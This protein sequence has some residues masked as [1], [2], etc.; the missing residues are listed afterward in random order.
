MDSGDLNLQFFELVF[1]E[2]NDFSAFSANHMIVML[3]EVAVLI[4]GLA[5]VKSASV[6]KTKTAHELQGFAHKLRVHLAAALRQ[7]LG[8]FVNGN[9]L[10]GL[11][12]DFEDI[13]S[14][15]K[16]INVLLLKQL[17]ELFFFLKMNLFHW[18]YFD[19]PGIS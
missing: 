19:G 16:I 8:Q 13:K 9:M 4:S 10:F 5:V 14:I 18:D 3:T 15:F 2:F 7:Q 12:K 17:F 11:Q 6:S 1:F